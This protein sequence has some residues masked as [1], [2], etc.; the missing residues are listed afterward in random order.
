MTMKRSHLKTSRRIWLFYF[1]FKT[2]LEFLCYVILGWH[3][4]PYQSILISQI[5][6]NLQSLLKIPL[7]TDQ[8]LQSRKANVRNTEPVF[9]DDYQ[10]SIRANSANRDEWHGW[11]WKG[12]W[13]NTR[14]MH[15]LWRLPILTTSNKNNNK[16]QHPEGPKTHLASQFGQLPAHN[17]WSNPNFSFHKQKFNPEESKWTVLGHIRYRSANGIS[18]LLIQSPQF[19]LRFTPVSLGGIRK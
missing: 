3:F 5:V 16:W 18:W 8:S 14:H 6:F 19:P 12:L 4:F 2:Y 11:G 17:S 9:L 13:G 15:L 10:M 7:H 1:H